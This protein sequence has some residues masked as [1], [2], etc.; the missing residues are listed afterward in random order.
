MSAMDCYKV[1]ERFVLIWTRLAGFAFIAFGQECRQG[2]QHYA[3]S[4]APHSAQFS[5]RSL[6]PHRNRDGGL[7]LLKPLL[8]DRIKIT[9][10][11]EG[12][13]MCERPGLAVHREPT[14]QMLVK[15]ILYLMLLLNAD[16]RCL[17]PILPKESTQAIGKVCVSK[18]RLC[19]LLWWYWLDYISSSLKRFGKCT[20]F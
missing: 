15:S 4:P 1:R 14:P 9:Y 12:Q 19:P 11:Y 8:V 6:V 18:S 10:V 13:H 2:A 17:L 3:R 7:G 5:S 20:C 16:Q